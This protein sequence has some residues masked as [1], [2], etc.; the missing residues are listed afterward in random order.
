[1]HALAGRLRYRRTPLH[2]FSSAA[3]VAKTWPPGWVPRW[4]QLSVQPPV[5]L[6]VQLPAVV[7]LWMVPP[8]VS[9]QV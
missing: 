3:G 7:V 5:R 9:V 8:R 1:M 6:Q 4:P 2:R